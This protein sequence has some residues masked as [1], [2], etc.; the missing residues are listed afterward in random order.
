MLTA[1]LISGISFPFR[2]PRRTFMSGDKS[3]ESPRFKQPLKI[4]TLN[5]R[6]MAQA[7][8]IDNAIQEMKKMNIEI[9][10]VSEMT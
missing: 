10:G 1:K 3:D 8:N 2:S 6:I 9:M 4:C 7:G 5:V